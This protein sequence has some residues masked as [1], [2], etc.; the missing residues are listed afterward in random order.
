MTDQPDR[1][2]TWG[3]T[4]IRPWGEFTNVLEGDGFKVDRRLTNLS[5]VDLRLIEVEC[6]VF[7]GEDD[8]VR[9]E[10]NYGRSS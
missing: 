4:K 1:E 10:D 5:V 9:L 2:K 3:A 8:I 7:F 6:G